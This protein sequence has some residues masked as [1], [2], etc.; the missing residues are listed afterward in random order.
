MLHNEA[1]EDLLDSE[2]QVELCDV[3][4][5][6]S[7]SGK[8]YFVEKEKFTQKHHLIELTLSYDNGHKR[9]NWERQDIF[10]TAE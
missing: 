9:W 6:R 1:V 3:V 5:I 2:K 10:S 7:Y 4:P 8:I